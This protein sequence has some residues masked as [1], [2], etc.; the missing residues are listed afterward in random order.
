M[1]ATI[2]NTVVVTGYTRADLAAFVS[3]NFMVVGVG[4]PAGVVSA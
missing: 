1:F 3:L 4:P 2:S